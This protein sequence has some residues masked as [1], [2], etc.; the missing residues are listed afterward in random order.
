MK[1]FAAALCCMLLS[2]G[3][4]SQEP[5]P[6]S[7]RLAAARAI[8]QQAGIAQYEYGYNKF[9][10]CH[11][12]TPPETL[13]SVDAGVVTDVRHRMAKTGDI[14]PARDGSF[15]L[16]WTIDDLFGLLERASNGTASVQADFDPQTGVPQ[17]LYI[18]Y[19]PDL[20]GDEIDVRVTAFEAR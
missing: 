18:D 19:M 17:R 12:E 15:D 2:A 20:I 10:E 13:V 16:Y 9:C 1:R 7:E 6:L 3:G 14:V 4:W 11:A 8:W 5:A